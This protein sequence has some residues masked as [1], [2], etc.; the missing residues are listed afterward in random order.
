MKHTKVVTLAL[1]LVAS[2]FVQAQSGCLIV[3]HKG[4]VGRRLI[5]TAL[6]GVPIAPGTKYDLVDSISYQ[7]QRVA[8]T[9]KELREVEKQTR[10]IVLEKNYKQ[11]EIDSARASCHTESGK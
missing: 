9:D 8:Y 3:K 10:V 4:T 7:P 5:W 6:T 2:Q 11:P 1:V